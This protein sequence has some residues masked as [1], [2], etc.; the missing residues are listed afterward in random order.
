MNKTMYFL[1]FPFVSHSLRVVIDEQRI[2]IDSALTFKAIL[3]SSI[4]VHEEF[5]AE[6]SESLL[7]EIHF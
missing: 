5:S 1:H 6:W 3:S 4:T 2:I 7:S